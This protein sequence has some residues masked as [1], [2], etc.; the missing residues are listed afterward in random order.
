MQNS[1]DSYLFYLTYL[2]NPHD[3]VNAV[4]REKPGLR[5]RVQSR[6]RAWKTS[7]TIHTSLDKRDIPKKTN[8]TN[9]NKKVFSLCSER[10]RGVDVDA[11]P[12]GIDAWDAKEAPGLFYGCVCCFLCS[13][14][15]IFNCCFSPSRLT[16]LLFLDNCFLVSHNLIFPPFLI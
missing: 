4:E 7:V 3:L 13:V 12:C 8:K 5:E 10:E 11:N 2:K 6:S 16:G 14:D 15:R 9:K 1:S